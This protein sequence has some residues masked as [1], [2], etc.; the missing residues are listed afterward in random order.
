ERLLVDQRTHIR[1]G[2]EAVA[3]AERLGPLDESVEE[4]IVD[5]GVEEQPAGCRAALPG[6]AERA[7]EHAVEGELEIRIGHHDLRVLAAHLEAQ[8]LVHAATDLADARP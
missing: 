6:R 2:V 1:V 5:V 8:A 3:E 7:P 4:S